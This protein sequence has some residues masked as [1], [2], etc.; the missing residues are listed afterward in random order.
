[1]RPTR[2]GKA[3]A[4]LSMASV[5]LEMG[6]AVIVGWAVGQ[7]LD[8]RFGSEPYLMLLF[9]LFGVAAAFKGL[10]RAGLQAKRDVQESQGQDAAP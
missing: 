1:M 8:D 9:L 2:A 5:G 7:W 4:T 6:L 10:I 3:F